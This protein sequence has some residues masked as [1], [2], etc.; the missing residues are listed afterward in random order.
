M[1][2][3]G[4]MRLTLFT[5]YGLRTLMRLAEEPE[6][7]FT[8]E[9]IARELKLSRHHLTKVV[10]T[11]G[12][13]G[14]VTTLRGV[15]GG[16]R[17]ARPAEEIRIG[18]VARRL[19]GRQALV[20]CFRPDGGGCTF[21]PRCR[22]KGRLHAA[23]EAFFRELDAMTLAECALPASDAEPRAAAP[24]AGEGEPVVEMDE[25]RLRARREPA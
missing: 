2:Q 18:A 4:P 8:T 9:A 10:R 3:N 14:Y 1:R 7:I 13:A 16:F 19:E 20:E 21:T 17:L 11:L 22:L 15:G 24:D 5:D 25:V 12:A 23:R 6:R